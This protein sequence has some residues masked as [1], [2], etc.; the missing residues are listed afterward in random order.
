MDGKVNDYYKCQPCVYLGM[1][2]DTPYCYEGYPSRLIKL[3]STNQCRQCD[4]YSC[5]DFDRFYRFE[6]KGDLKERLTEDEILH[7]WEAGR[8]SGKNLFLHSNRFGS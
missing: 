8:Q 2:Q 3:T 6:I 5:W 4:S 7:I 1:E